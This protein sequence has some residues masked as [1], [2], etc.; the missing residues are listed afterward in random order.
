ML[1]LS[2]QEEYPIMVQVMKQGCSFHLSPL[3]CERNV[4]SDFLP[5]FLLC[6]LNL[7]KQP[8]MIL[9]EIFSEMC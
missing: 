5:S 1:T 9:H 7:T 3:V 2:Q 8:A 4:I 6:V